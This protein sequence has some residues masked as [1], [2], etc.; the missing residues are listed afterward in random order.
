VL[1]RPRVRP[2]GLDDVDAL[3]R[4]ELH[5]ALTAYAHIFPPDAPV[6]TLEQ[7][8]ARWRVR[9]TR[10]P[11]AGAVF[12]VGDP[13]VGLVMG[14]PA[15]ELDP[16]PEAHGHLRA[17]YVDPD[18][19]GEGLGRALHDTAV[20]YLR[21]CRPQLDPLTLWVMERNTRARE[22]YEKWGWRRRD[23]RQEIWPGIDELRY[24]LVR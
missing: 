2:A 14:D 11:V 13:I 6:P 16:D 18:H 5:T 12:V 22:R 7:F 24:E 1:P 23:E 17:L 15:P 21:V 9:L 3:A 20:E 10:E 19:W 4:V 8:V